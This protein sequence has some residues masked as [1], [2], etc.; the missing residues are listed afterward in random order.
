MTMKTFADYDEMNQRAREVHVA[1]MAERK[2]K[3]RTYSR[4]QLLAEDIREAV[5]LKR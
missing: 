3:V 2:R 5:R 1:A 4:K